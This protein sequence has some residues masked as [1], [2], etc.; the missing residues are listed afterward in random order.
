MDN[1]T[2]EFDKIK[3]IHT[4]IGLKLKELSESKDIQFLMKIQLINGI[5]LLIIQLTVLLLYITIIS[6]LPTTASRN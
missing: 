3:S 6:I 2:E 1:N 4:K 5:N